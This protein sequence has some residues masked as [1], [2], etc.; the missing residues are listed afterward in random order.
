MNSSGNWLV[1]VDPSVYKAIA[2]FP[3]KDATRILDAVDGFVSDPYGGDAAKLG[4][5]ERDWRRRIGSYRIFYEIYAELKRVEVYRV[6]RRGS[7]TY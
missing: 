5:M 7:K 6:E 4:G 3:R 1:R 2:R